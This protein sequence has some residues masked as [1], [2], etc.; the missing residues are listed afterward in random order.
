MNTLTLSKRQIA[1]QNKSE[2]WLRGS[3]FFIVVVMLVSFSWMMFFAV[4]VA[5]LTAKKNS[6]ALA[7]AETNSEISKLEREYMNLMSVFTT[8][9]ALQ[10]GYST[11]AQESF[12]RVN[13]NVTTALVSQ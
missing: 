8:D 1:D 3:Y 13:E 10:N 6:L 9:Y 2:R 12:V 11:V 5:G 7:N 4:S